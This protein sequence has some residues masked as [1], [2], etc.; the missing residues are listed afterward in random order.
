MFQVKRHKDVPERPLKEIYASAWADFRLLSNVLQHLGE[1]MHE[2]G[3]TSLNRL[4]K[5]RIWRR[6]L[7]PGQGLRVHFADALG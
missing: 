5:K 4:R 1:L 2:N 3:V 7:A 6:D